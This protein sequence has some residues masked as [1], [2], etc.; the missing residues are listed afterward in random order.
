MEGERTAP[1]R[2]KEGRVNAPGNG[3]LSKFRSFEASDGVAASLLLKLWTRTRYELGFRFGL[4]NERFPT[5]YLYSNLRRRR[6]F[7]M[8]TQ[9]VRT[10]SIAPAKTS[11]CVI[12]EMLFFRTR[13]RYVMMKPPRFTTN[14]KD[15]A[16]F[17]IA[18]RRSL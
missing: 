16:P 18:S 7:R 12:V 14:A 4:C 6:R 9:S 10:L 17:S 8:E 2:R 11:Q 5:A 13:S 15:E 1:S 3:M